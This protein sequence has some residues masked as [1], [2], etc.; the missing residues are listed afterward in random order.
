[1]DY[2]LPQ[3]YLAY[4][5]SDSRQPWLRMQSLGFLPYLAAEASYHAPSAVSSNRTRYV[6]KN[7]FTNGTSSPHL[8]Y[9]WHVS[10]S[11]TS[12]KLPDLLDRCSLSDRRLDLLR[13]LLGH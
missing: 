11:Q 9:A 2:R 10:F 12:L 13:V 5:L 3:G 4:G 1:M 7:T 8:L 6:P